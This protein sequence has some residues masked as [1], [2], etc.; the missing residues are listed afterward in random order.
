MSFRRKLLLVFALTVSVSV[1]A[2][3]WIVS[4]VTGR[5]FE[6]ANEERSTALVSQF[7]REFNRR[8]EDLLHRVEAI[9][10]SD[11]VTRMALALSRASADNGSYFNDAKSIAEAQQLDFLE[12]VDGQGTIISSAQSPAKFGY[13]ENWLASGPNPSSD[14]FSKTRGASRICG[15]GIIRRSHCKH[16]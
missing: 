11:S 4:D 2:I 16:R 15:V 9:A 12:F 14:R 6:R 10:A 1:A 3:A 8:G 5:A 7:Q 13:K